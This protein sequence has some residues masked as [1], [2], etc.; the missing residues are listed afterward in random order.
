MARNSMNATEKRIYYVFYAVI[1]LLGVSI[2]YIL[3][4]QPTTIAHYTAGVNVL[5]FALGMS[6]LSFLLILRREA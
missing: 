6:C 4:T 3:H 2:P 5:A 1:G